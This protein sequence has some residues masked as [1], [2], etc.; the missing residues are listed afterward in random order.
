MSADLYILMTVPAGAEPVVQ[1]IRPF[2]R[3][4]LDSSEELRLKAP[5]VNRRQSPYGT[6]FT[7]V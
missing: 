4:T 3:I 7:K 6:D 5:D 1:K 2:K